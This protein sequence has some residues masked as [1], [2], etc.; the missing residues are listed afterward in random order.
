MRSLPRGGRG[1]ARRNYHLLEL[2][3][4]AGFQVHVVSLL[5]V[6]QSREEAIESVRGV[7]RYA[8]L[9]ERQPWGL[10]RGLGAWARSDSY[11]QAHDHHP[12]MGAKVAQLLP[13]SRLVVNVDPL[14][15][16]VIADAMGKMKGD[17]AGQDR[18]FYLLDLGEP[19]STQL[20]TCAKGLRGVRS[21]ACRAEANAVKHLEHTAAAEADLTLL[22]N[23]IDL[24]LLARG[25][26]SGK[27]WAIGDGVDEHETQWGDKIEQLPNH[28]LFCGDLALE[29]HQK[30]AQW[31]V[32]TVMPM[33]RRRHP[34]TVLWLV[35][36]Q[37]PASIRRLEKQGR[38]KLSDTAVESM[39]LPLAMRQCVVGVAPQHESRGTSASVLMMLATR[40]PVVCTP[41]VAA[42][43]PGDAATGPIVAE[44]APQIADAVVKLLKDRDAAAK[45]GERGRSLVSAAATWQVQWCRVAALLTQIA[46]GEPLKIESDRTAPRRQR[47]QQDQP[48]P[49]SPLRP[50]PGA[51]TR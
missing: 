1:A 23:E 43:L 16:R 48:K 50:V 47:R 39:S 18:P 22:S 41:E 34:G 6:G 40:R 20:V 28:V 12:A 51:R 14:L 45:S 11:T 29:P 10:W 44:R 9:F 25:L 8:H 27:L 30:T 19:P 4:E 26:R 35:G 49:G 21:W 17:G 37:L 13:Q 24:A 38:V 15:H 42:L 46:K 33:I 2:V 31:F 32:Q 36:R 3:R 5:E 7:C